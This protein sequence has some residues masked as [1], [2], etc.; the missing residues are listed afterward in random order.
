MSSKSKNR[1]NITLDG[2]VVKMSTNSGRNSRN[3]TKAQ[4]YENA[5][6]SDETGY[7]MTEVC[8]LLTSIKTDL[9][10]VKQDFKKNVKEENL[11][12]LV[13]DILQKLLIENN[14]VIS[15]EIEQKCKSLEKKIMLKVDKLKNDVEVLEGR[16]ETLSEK[17][18]DC[19]KSLREMSKT[20]S[21]SQL[22]AIEALRRSNHN[23]QFSRKTNFKIMGVPE[24]DRENTWELVKSFLKKTA[25]IELAD[26]EMIAAHRIPGAKG[27]I[28]PII[29]KVLNTSVK[30]RIM[31]MR[32]TVKTK[33]GG[34]RLADDITKSNAELITNLLKFEGIESAW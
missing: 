8:K 16:V 24:E 12:K 31:R 34:S 23:E 1:K 20:V 26:H 4:T 5:T 3:S 6:S 7:S 21:D 33:G 29:V 18:N 22:A 32:A 11:E 25:K 14:K 28:R 13:T 17:Y 10:E 19:R 9:S 2:Y 27:K 30:S 15:A